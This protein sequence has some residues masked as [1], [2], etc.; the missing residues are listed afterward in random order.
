MKR[1]TIICGPT[2]CPHDPNFEHDN[3]FGCIPK[4]F[5]ERTGKSKTYRQTRHGDRYYWNGGCAAR[6][7][8]EVEG[9][10]AGVQS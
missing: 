7:L 8:A 9:R 10:T 1:T 5:R 4:D 6:K 2:T 3:Y